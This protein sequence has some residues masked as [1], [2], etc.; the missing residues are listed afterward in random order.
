MTL[1]FLPGADFRKP[2]MFIDFLFDR[3]VHHTESIVNKGKGA[4]RQVTSGPILH[5]PYMQY[6]LTKLY[7]GTE[8]ILSRQRDWRSA[9]RTSLYF[10]DARM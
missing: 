1:S 9:G 7:P 3:I 6:L 4:F 8:F 2:G 5:M 10:A